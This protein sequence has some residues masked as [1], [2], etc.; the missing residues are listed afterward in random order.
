M[1]LAPRSDPARQE[2]DAFARA[3]GAGDLAA[4]ERLYRA[5]VARVHTPAR[6]IVGGDADEATQEIYLAAWRRLA[7]WRGEAGV[8][9][10]LHRL[11]LN[12]LL[13]R[14]GRRGFPETGAD[15]HLGALAAPEASV[16]ARI[17]LE[18]A[19]AALP[20]GARLVFVLRELEGH[21]H[22]EVAA[23]LGISVGTSKSQLHRARMLLR[24]ALGEGRKT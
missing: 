9:T 23:R 18:E 17:E 3:A 7:S 11:A 19:I 13:D 1:E 20:E 6:R 21:T 10:W 4:F 15:E 24:G 16:G 12:A 2:L 8:A 5:T 22:G 14:A